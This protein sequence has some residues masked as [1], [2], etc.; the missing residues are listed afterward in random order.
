MA[1][2]E[3]VAL[4][5]LREFAKNWE[6]NADAVLERASKGDWSHEQRI[7]ECVNH[8]DNLMADWDRLVNRFRALLVE[9]RVKVE[10]RDFGRG[11][12]IGIEDIKACLIPHD[13]LLIP[14]GAAQSIV[15][16]LARLGIKAKEA[17]GTPRD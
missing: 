7:N 3:D 17:D 4:I 15:D 10:L 1:Y 6:A 11:V 2:P 12:A 5:E 16:Q 14:R 9:P 8:L 13:A